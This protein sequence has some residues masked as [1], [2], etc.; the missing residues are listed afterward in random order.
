MLKTGSKGGDVEALQR[1]LKAAGFDPGVI[2]GDF[3]PATAKAL[4]SF[5]EKAGIGADGIFGPQTEDK[6]SAAINALTMEGGHEKPA[7]GGKDDAAPL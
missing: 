1:R 2:D 3:G 5:Q 6:L 7:A 4:R